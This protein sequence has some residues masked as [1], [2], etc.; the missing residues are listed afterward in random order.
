MV[1]LEFRFRMKG[2]ESKGSVDVGDERD[3]EGELMV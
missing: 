1:I 3:S 2:K